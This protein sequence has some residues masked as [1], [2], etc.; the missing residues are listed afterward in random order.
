VIGHD[1]KTDLALLK[2]DAPRPLPTA[3]WGD[4][5]KAR[6][7]DRVLAI[8]NP[9]GLGGTVTAGIISA[10][11]RDINVGPY[12]DFIQTDAAISRGNSGGPMFDM[13]G[14]VIGINTAI[15][16]PSG[17]SIRISFALPSSLAKGIIPQL[18][19]YGHPRRSW[20]GVRIQGVTPELAEA[21]KLSK[22]TGALVTAVVNGSPADRAGIKRGDVVIRFNDQEVTEMR[23]LPRIVA[24]TPFNRLVPVMVLRRGKLVSLQVRL[25][26]LNEAAEAKPIGPTNKLLAPPRPPD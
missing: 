9:F 25:R 22:P 5:D 10:R 4:S 1:P 7:G 17:D 23:Y 19:Q 26:E 6:V 20:L 21:C 8:G 14:K 18:R 13:D 2:I 11:Q 15:F 16:S 3:E 12:D 24:Q